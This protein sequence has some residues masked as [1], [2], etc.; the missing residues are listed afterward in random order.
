MANITPQMVKDLREKT[1]AGMADCKKALT[2]TDGDMTTAI[3]FLRKK[4]AASAAKRA[5]KTASEGRIFVKTS[6]DMKTGVMVEVNCETDFVAMNDEFLKFVDIVGNTVMNGDYK[7][8]DDM[9]SVEIEGA[10]IEQHYNG[11]LAKFSEKI[12]VRRFEKVATEGSVVTYL[13]SNG[14]LGVLI[15]ITAPTLEGA[16]LDSAKDITMQIAAMNPTFIDRSAVDQATI[17]KE[18]EIYR[19]QAI[20]SG[21]KEEIA[22]RIA[23]GRVEKF[24]GESCLVEQTFVKDNKKVV[25]DIL[26]EIGADVKVSS[27]KRFAL[28][29]EA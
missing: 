21:K 26:K 1:G 12:E 28:G 10:T 17:D 3:E 23:Q 22:D 4:G 15:D 2:E 20:E 18:I 8:Y 6:D 19:T 13:H 9:K 27:F 7:S 14:K 5:D 29:E 24:Y 11:I 16:A 25:S